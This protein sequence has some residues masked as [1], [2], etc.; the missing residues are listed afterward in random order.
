MLQKANVP[1]F[2]VEGHLDTTTCCITQPFTG[3]VVL[4]ILSTL[5]VS[6]IILCNLEQQSYFLHTHKHTFNGP[7][8]ATTR[9]SRYQKGKN[10]SGFY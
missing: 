6:C 10:Q 9:V 8:S 3:E 2:E 1:K 4:L 5:S 7:L